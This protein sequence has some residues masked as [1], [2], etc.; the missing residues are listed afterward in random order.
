MIVGLDRAIKP[1]W[2]YRILK[3]S[4][5]GTDYRELEPQFFSLIDLEGLRSKKNILKII[6]RYFLNIKKIRGVE[7]ID[8]NQLHDLC[9]QYSYDSIKPLFLFVL[10]SKCEI[11][12]FIQSKINLMFACNGK[13]DSGLLLAN[14]KKTYGDRRIVR[15]SV[16]YY[17]TILTYFEI[18]EK[19]GK[20]YHWKT[21]KIVCTNPILKEILLVY[22]NLFQK[23][24]IDLAEI[25]ENI[26][27]SLFDLTNLEDTIREYNS[28]EWKYQRR[29][30]SNKIII[31]K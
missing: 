5:P 4:R 15:Y 16:S 21:Y 13:I 26:I 30:D 6:R 1:E 29:L 8:E 24:E 20:S 7:Y 31:I 14:V 18:L 2:I 27:F 10:L 17:L 12:Q 22:A 19:Q 3:L 11:A 23:Q 25:Y 9:V 28:K